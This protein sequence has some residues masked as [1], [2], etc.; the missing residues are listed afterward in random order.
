MINKVKRK[1][2][3]GAVILSAVMSLAACDLNG[4]VST[5]DQVEPHRERRP[6]PGGPEGRHG[7]VPSPGAAE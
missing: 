7:K 4:L 6:A 2:V 3:L 5:S 1:F